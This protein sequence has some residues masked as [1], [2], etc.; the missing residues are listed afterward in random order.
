[1]RVF[2][3]AVYCGCIGVWQACP[4]NA[5]DSIQ[6]RQPY[7]GEQDDDGVDGGQRRD[8]EHDAAHARYRKSTT[9]HSADVDGLRRSAAALQPDPE[10]NE[11]QAEDEQRRQGDEDDQPRVRIAEHPEQVRGHQRHE[12]HGAAVVISH[13]GEGDGVAEAA[14]GRSHELYFRLCM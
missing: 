4:Q 9:G 11:Q 5:G 8:G 7:A 2:C 3:Q 14:R 12:R 6:C 13:P 10:G 1:M